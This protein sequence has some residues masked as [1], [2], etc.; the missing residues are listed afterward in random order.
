VVGEL[1]GKRIA[2]LVANEGVE[3]IE[4]TDPWAAIESA[5]GTPVLVAPRPG[6]VQ[7]YNHLSRAGKFPVHQPVAEARAGDYAGLLLPG[8]VANPDQLRMDGEAVAFAR[9]FATAGKPVAAIC[10]APWTLIEAGAVRGNT[11]TSWP[12]LH[13]DITNAGGTWVDRDV[14]VCTDAGYPL[15]TSRRPDD[16][17]AFCREAVR[18][19]AANPIR[20]ARKTTRK[21]PGR[22]S[23]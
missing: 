6:I 21:A 5:G 2:F 19:F 14:V 4:L 11:L 12:S 1:A 15:V 16:L 7:A 17:P 13:T 3:Q 23:R 10:H 18:A 8:G 9:G 20:P 22:T